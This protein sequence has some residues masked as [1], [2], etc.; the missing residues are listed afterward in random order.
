M[1]AW[2]GAFIMLLVAGCA[3]AAAPSTAPLV[4]LEGSVQADASCAVRTALLY[5]QSTQEVVDERGDNVRLRGEWPSW[6]RGGLFRA[7]GLEAFRDSNAFVTLHVLH[8]LTLLRDGELPQ[9][10]QRLTPVKQA[11]GEMLRAHY[12]DARGE[13][14][15][16][17]T[18]DGF[19]GPHQIAAQHRW[20]DAL[21]APLHIPND[22]DDTAL[23]HALFPGQAP[24]VGG[25]FSPWRDVERSRTDPRED[26]KQPNS[27]AF[28]TW[29]SDERA[30]GNRQPASPLMPNNVDCVVQ[31]NVIWALAAR[32]ALATPGVAESCALVGK[33]LV[34]HQYPACAHYY[35]SHWMLPYAAARAL[36][37]GGATCVSQPGDHGVSPLLAMVDTSLAF[38]Q[39]DGAWDD[40][41]AFA[42][43]PTDVAPRHGE[44]GGDAKAFSTALNLNTLLMVRD[45]TEV[46]ARRDA[47][48]AAI[49]RG[50]A[51]LT[52]HATHQDGQ[53]FWQ[54]GVFFSASLPWLAV[55]K[56]RPLTTALVLEASARILGAPPLELTPQTVPEAW[57]VETP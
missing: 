43:E 44:F 11:A 16:W 5:M 25:L 8:V 42:N 52:T 26:W 51:W 46:A 28:L 6:V 50:F 15:F 29:L 27:G 17:P 31:A 30:A 41:A 39:A 2:V 20:V 45:L 24:D 55:W 37:H 3:G 19:H 1:R 48:E 14:N 40:N 34:H 53:V 22:A 9:Q 7:R 21:G 32:G 38:Q 36:V 18:L 13:V 54:G 12:V 4:C 33:A 23:F 57:L 10:A 49:G 56:S 47:V 35:P